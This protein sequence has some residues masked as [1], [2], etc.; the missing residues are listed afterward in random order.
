M[1]SRPSERSRRTTRWL[2][3]LGAILGLLTWLYDYEFFLNAA[4]PEAAIS[5]TILHATGTAHAPPLVIVVWPA[6][7]L[8]LVGMC[9]GYVT[10]WLFGVFW[11]ESAW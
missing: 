10:S 7:A 8:V 11:W 1:S 4:G 2:V 5:D 6:V 3:L 9:G